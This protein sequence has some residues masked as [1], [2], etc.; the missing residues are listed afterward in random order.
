M[1]TDN[2][3]Q[4]PLGILAGGGLLPRRLAD[5]AA[6]SGR[7][8]FLIAFQGQTDLATVEGYPHAWVRLGEAGRI[9]DALK[10]ADVAEIVMV[11]PVRRPSWSEIG[12]DWRGAQFIARIGARAL[13]DDGL[14][15]AVASELESEGF[16]LV[17][18]H[19]LLAE[20]FVEAGPLGRGV[21]DDQA[22]ADIARGIEVGRALGA[23]DVGQ[24]VVVQ[25]GMVLGV[26]AIEGTDALL[27]RVAGL[28]RDGPGG[29]LV[30]IAKP[31]QD[32]R[33]DLPTI[34]PN[35]VAKAVAA[36][37]RGIAIEAGATIVVDRPVCIDQANK[38]G[39]FII[40]LSAREICGQ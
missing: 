16:K 26:E 20:G 35:T 14:L 9:I 2:A 19:T 36:G 3:A 30:K 34:G 15:S 12:L 29:V 37:L 32:R 7:S 40:G 5:T 6:S 11:G 17:G 1:G 33:M 25:Q 31:G 10:R 24:S 18:A 4:K 21:P 23:V 13:G 28:S 38:A 8:V 27:D 22:L 39:L